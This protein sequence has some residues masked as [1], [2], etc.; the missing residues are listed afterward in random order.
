[1]SI[2]VF[3]DVSEGVQQGVEH[4]R[5]VRHDAAGVTLPYCTTYFLKT[6]QS[7]MSRLLMSL[8]VNML[9]AF[10]SLTL[11][12]M[13]WIR[14]ASYAQEAVVVFYRVYHRADRGVDVRP[15]WRHHLLV[16]VDAS[17]DVVVVQVGFRGAGGPGSHAGLAFSHRHVQL[18]SKLFVPVDIV[19]PLFVRIHAF[20]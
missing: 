16:H 12:R 8:R 2:E 17:A 10:W 13:N 18:V 15:H 4:L 3:V 20:Y 19:F 7:I 5:L 14:P 11:S 6:L 1:M 9:A